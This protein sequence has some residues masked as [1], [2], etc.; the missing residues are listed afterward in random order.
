[1]NLDKVICSMCERIIDKNNLLFPRECLIKY[2]KLAHG[3]CQ[4]CWWDN[5]IGFAREEA[6]HK[7][8]GCIKS[9]PL[10][11]YKK[12]PTIFIDLTQK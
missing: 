10:T 5:E 11:Y 3:I 1:M 7:C 2:G 6:S 9:L 12:G 8:P 4:N